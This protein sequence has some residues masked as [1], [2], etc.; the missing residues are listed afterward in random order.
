MYYRNLKFDA[1]CVD[2]KGVGRVNSF[3]PGSALGPGFDL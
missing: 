1:C 2:S 3:F